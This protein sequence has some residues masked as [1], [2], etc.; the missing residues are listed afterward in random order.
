M[1]VMTPSVTKNIEPFQELKNPERVFAI[2]DFKCYITSIIR[3]IYN[4]RAD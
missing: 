3:E 4:G 2:Q 1:D